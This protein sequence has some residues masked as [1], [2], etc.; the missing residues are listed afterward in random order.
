MKKIVAIIAL[1]LFANFV[2]AQEVST[3]SPVPVRVDSIIKLQ[4]FL[5]NTDYPIHLINSLNQSIWGLQEEN[6]KIKFRYTL[7][8]FINWF[9]GDS[10]TE[11][12]HRN[13]LQDGL[14]YKKKQ[15]HAW[16]AWRK[17]KN[18]AHTERLEE[19][20]DRITAHQKSVNRRRMNNLKAKYA[21]RNEKLDQEIALKGKRE[22]WEA[23]RLTISLDKIQIVMKDTIDF[24]YK[25]INN[26]EKNPA[27]RAAEDAMKIKVI[28]SMPLEML[29][30]L[31][32]SIPRYLRTQPKY[33][34]LLWVIPTPF[35]TKVQKR[36]KE[37]W[38]LVSGKWNT[39]L[40][41]SITD[42]PVVFPTS[43]Y[44]HWSE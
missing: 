40:V 21:L 24:I 7:D 22:A 32:L 37:T 3:K 38:S 23:D 35:E 1:V 30:V 17:K 5:D 16:L 33:K 6:R 11:Y 44:Y 12:A 42:K 20:D 8:S 36:G 29:A 27:R 14:D 39:K 31:D 2:F 10:I 4:L 15:R 26:P 9:Q 34:K 19:T 43:R 13:K 25:T 41:Q 28:R 18:Q